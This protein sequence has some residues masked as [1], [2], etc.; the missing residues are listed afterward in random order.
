ME[1]TWG[2]PCTTTTYGGGSSV[3]RSTTGTWSLRWSFSAEIACRRF[4]FTEDWNENACKLREIITYWLHLHCQIWEH[5]YD[6][7]Q[8]YAKVRL[9]SFWQ[10]LMFL[11]VEISSLSFSYTWVFPQVRLSS[12]WQQLMLLIVEKSSLSFS[13]TWENN[14]PWG[15]SARCRLC[16]SSCQLSASSWLWP[17]ILQFDAACALA[18]KPLPCLCQYVSALDS[19][20]EEQEDAMDEENTHTVYLSLFSLSLSLSPSPT[21]PLFLLS[22]CLSSLSKVLKP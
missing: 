10:N 11:I 9:S 4:A 19:T 3:A 6:P 17:L 16:A 1:G 7:N 20:M 5:T 18:L 21:L 12:F 15:F 2:G 13:Y 22:L 8:E 14:E